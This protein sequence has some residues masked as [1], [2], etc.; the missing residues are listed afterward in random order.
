MAP[1]VSSKIFY[2][3]LVRSPDNYFFDILKE[4]R[5]A[6]MAA[7]LRAARSELH[8][9][10][11]LNQGSKIFESRKRY[12]DPGAVFLMLLTGESQIG[13]AM[14]AGSI[15]S[16]SREIFCIELENGSARELEKSLPQYLKRASRKL[17]ERDSSD[18]E[19]F[20]RMARVSIS[21]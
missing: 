17:P 16:D 4:V 7:D 19:S 3:D 1:Q 13:K 8:I 11:A 15:K 10:S 9:L 12:R 14:D 5:K 18:E 6:I 2:Y 20:W 21:L